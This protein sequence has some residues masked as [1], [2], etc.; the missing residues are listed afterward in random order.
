MDGPLG[1]GALYGGGAVLWTSFMREQKSASAVPCLQSGDT[2]GNKTN[3]AHHRCWINIPILFRT[4]PLP[5]L[6]HYL[7]N[8]AIALAGVPSLSRGM[9]IMM[10][11]GRYWLGA[12]GGKTGTLCSNLTVQLF[13]S[14]IAV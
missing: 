4:Q 2:A 10:C 7:T 1:A 14:R 9:Y 5:P 12:L 8:V 11:T 6:S 3:Y 13:P